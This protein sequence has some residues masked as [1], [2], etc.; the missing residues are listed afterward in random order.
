M[1]MQNPT[2]HL[3][4]EEFADYLLELSTASA[5]AHLLECAQC[6]DEME[7]FGASLASFNQTSMAWSREQAAAHPI[8]IAPQPAAGRWPRPYWQTGWAGLAAAAV[9]AFAVALPVVL[10]ER[11]SHSA[12][13]SNPAVE[14]PGAAQP[15][16]D[17]SVIAE[18]NQ[19]MTAIDAEVSQP[20]ISPVE[21]FATFRL[22]QSPEHAPVRDGRHAVRKK[23]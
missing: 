15:Q 16:E 3:T 10:H 2:P 5:R 4:E 19:M 9:L 7:S 21:S 6:R 18:D 13:A 17:A 23:S 22:Q 8:H 1:T 11:A 14:S 12:V 20:D